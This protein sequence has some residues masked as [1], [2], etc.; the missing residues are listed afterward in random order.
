M[1][2]PDKVKFLLILCSGLIFFMTGCVD[3][4]VQTIPDQIVYHSQAKI[5]NLVPATGGGTI[6][7]TFDGKDYTIDPGQEAPGDGQPFIDFI[8]GTKSITVKNANTNFNDLIPA[9]TE[10]KMRLFVVWDTTQVNHL[11]IDTTVITPDSLQIDTTVVL[12]SVITSYDVLTN[13]Q[14][15]VWQK[16]GTSEG[17]SLFPSDTIQ[18]AI[19]NGSPDLS[20][21]QLRLYGGDIDETVS[22][23][24]E[25]KGNS[26]YVKFGA[27]S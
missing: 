25:Y 12:D 15:Y 13:Y 16:K 6:T 2:I 21:S 18:I 20:V 24:A 27:P 22:A 23:S 10:Y 8:S 26:G 5:V 14:R 3:T 1:K 11:Q 19:F 7:A 9:Q 17:A 4:S